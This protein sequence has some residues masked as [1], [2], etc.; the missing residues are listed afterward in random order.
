M[1]FERV[2]SVKDVP[3]GEGRGFE[4][5]GRRVAVFNLGAGEVR[6]LEDICSHAHAYLSEGEV[7]PDDESV[8]CPRHGSTFELDSGRPTSLPATAPVQVFPVEVDGDDIL[9]DVEAEGG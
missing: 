7:D 4:L 5:N 8:E 9:I 3:E 6:A 2:A 1:A